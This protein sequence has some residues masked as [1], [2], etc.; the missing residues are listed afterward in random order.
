VLLWWWWV[1]GGG[2]GGGG[3]AVAVGACALATNCS[4]STPSPSCHHWPVYTVP[5]LCAL[6]LRGAVQ[7]LAQLRSSYPQGR[8]VCV[9]ATGPAPCVCAHRAGCIAPP[10][11]LPS[12][13]PPRARSVCTCCSHCQRLLL[14]H[15]CVC[16][17]QLKD[18]DILGR[19]LGRAKPEGM[20]K[21]FFGADG[22]CVGRARALAR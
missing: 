2:G 5:A 14:V 9:L 6:W 20:S 12:P 21:L 22:A 18:K 8:K 13:P 10:S 4:P 19:D 3:A 1:M 15:A 16:V 11:P 17:G 7:V